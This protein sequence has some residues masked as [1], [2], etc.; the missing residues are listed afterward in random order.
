[1]KIAVCAPAR[2]IQPLAAA[3][4]QAFAALYFPQAELVYDPQCFVV[5]GHFAGNDALRAETLLR[6]AN[7][8]AFDAIWFAR[9][10][11]GSNRILDEVLPALGPAARE[12]TY[13]GYSDMG[14]LLGALYARGIGKPVHGPMSTEATEA[15]RAAPIWR[16]LAWL[17]AQDRRALEPSLGDGRPGAAF[18]MA[19]LTAMLG[20]PYVPD[21]TDHVLMLEEVG[22]A[23]YR[24]D[25]MMW[26][27]ARATQLRGIAG[28]RLGS[29]TAITEGA[30]EAEFGE[31]LDG[32]M[33]RWCREMGVP[34]L[35]RARVGHDADNHVVPFG[36]A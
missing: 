18:N 32:I 12:K 7:D 27:I 29:V 33:Q 35:G 34:Y 10:G 14:F 1:M 24:I 30:G 4:G 28:I 3:R 26:Q 5:E 22:E 9:G 6:Y 21:L 31:S 13:M 20:T 16:A 36:V 15:N 2:S 11:Y 19:I 23:V 17:T 25:R 8:P